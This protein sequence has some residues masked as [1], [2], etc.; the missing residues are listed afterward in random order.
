MFDLV[1]TLA[2]T[3]LWIGLGYLFG[4]ALLDRIEVLRILVFVGPV[5]LISVLAFRWLRRQRY[6]TQ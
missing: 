2:Y 3:A 4:T 5:A 1:G 6:G